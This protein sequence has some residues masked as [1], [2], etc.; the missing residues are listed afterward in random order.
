ME[1]ICQLLRLKA[2]KWS[3]RCGLSDAKT[4]TLEKSFITKGYSFVL[5]GKKVPPDTWIYVG[6][7]C[8]KVHRDMLCQYGE[9][10]RALF[11]FEG[12]DENEVK[13][14]EFSGRT[15]TSNAFS[16]FLDFVY[17]KT[18][19][20]YDKGVLEFLLAADFLQIT[21]PFIDDL[22]KNISPEN[23]GAILE[24]AITF[25]SDR[26]ENAVYKFVENSYRNVH[27]TKAFKRLKARHPKL[28]DIST[29]VQ[30][31]C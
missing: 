11:S 26:L 29:F 5:D 23:W 7:F 9:Y 19:S 21:E 25:E 16:T 20:S 1:N 17:D 27:K 28:Q 13:E 12:Y 15:P 18:F 10:F 31:S 4:P 30:N 3:P 6:S 14:L 24:I 2:G 22:S 8:F